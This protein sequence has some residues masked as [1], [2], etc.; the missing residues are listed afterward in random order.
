MDNMGTVEHAAVIGTFSQ[1]KTA[2]DLLDEKILVQHVEY[3]GQT[4][5]ESLVQNVE[6]EGQTQ[7]THDLDSLGALK[8]VRLFWKPVLIAC[9]V[10]VAAI[11][12]GYCVTVPGSIIVSQGFIAVFGTIG[13]KADGT[14]AL[15]A[16]H[17]SAWGG[18]QSAGQIIGMI[19]GP[20]TSDYLGRKFNMFL[21]TG[22]LIIAAVLEIVA[23]EW[24][25]YLVAR[26]LAGWSTGLVQSGVTVY[27]AEIAP[28]PIRGALLAM[29]SLCFAVGQLS[30]SIAL[31][32]IATTSPLNYKLAF[33]SEFVFLG[34]FIPALIFAPESPWF[35]T[36]RGNEIKAK[37]SLQKLNGSIPGYDVDHAYGIMLE[38]IRQEDELHRDS[39]WQQT[40][41]CF[42]G[43]NLRRT[44]ISFIPLAFQQFLGISL[45]FGY[46]TYF[47][48]LAGYPKPFEAS[49]IISSILLAFIFI[50]FF[51]IDKFG[52]RPLL[53]GGGLVM[54][55]CTMS[56]GGIGFKE[57]LPGGALVALA[58]TW[59]AAYAL[60]AGPLGWAYV[61]DASS[62]RLRAKTAGIAASGTCLFG[63]IFNYTVPLMLSPQQA[64]WG[65]KI[66]LF[67]G[68][69]TIL[70]LVIIYFTV[71]EIKNRTFA[72]L[73]EIFGKKVATRSF[74][75]Y[76]TEV[77][78]ARE[79]Q[80]PAA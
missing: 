77:Q 60:S 2:H 59:V 5:V 47:F 80:V 18:V 52:R 55:I 69:L 22:L 19:S 21:L 7:V 37:S 70:G 74:G 54:A 15:S 23:K 34:M 42:K 39:F 51:V 49:L 11:F 38:V 31:Q 72:E 46:S 33:Y 41:D 63:L 29:Y 61:A 57:T 75:T 1:Q 17:V 62:P 16:Q 50:S 3:E 28:T 30:A 26:L 36:R 12:D 58:A 14:L 79:S 71:P 73:D 8:T 68:S 78:M 4:Q 45:I 65:I 67:F 9:L 13:S 6:Y 64:G 32:I 76:K 35:Y 56:I 20:L 25:V 48:Q 53:L 40:I 27:I 66:G 24:V 44:L 10:A 43:P